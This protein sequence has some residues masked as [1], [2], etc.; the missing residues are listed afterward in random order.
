[1]SPR[2]PASTPTSPCA[3]TASTS[4]LRR[5]APWRAGTGP[6]SW[7]RRGRAETHRFTLVCEPHRFLNWRETEG[8]DL[9][10]AAES[11]S[12]DGVTRRG[13]STLR[14]VVVAAVVLAGLVGGT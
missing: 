10:I 1:M 12:T 7:P 5:H 9:A 14:P 6:R 13:R 2:R 3:P 4:P 8:R 11:R